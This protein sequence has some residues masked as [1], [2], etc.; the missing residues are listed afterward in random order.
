MCLGRID[1]RVK[2]D[3]DKPSCV[4]QDND[5]ESYVIPDNESYI[6]PGLAPGISYFITSES[7]AIDAVNGSFVRD[8]A[9]GEIVIIDKQGLRSFKYDTPKKQTCIF[10]YVYFA[11]PDSI[12]DGI[13]VQ[14]ARYKMGEILARESKVPADVVIGVPDSGIGAAMGYSKAS[15]IRFYSCLKSY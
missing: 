15:S 11:R 7:C 2:P 12:I 4:K 9:P 3:N 5:K 14:E 1:C 10:E 6:I 8:I 13:P